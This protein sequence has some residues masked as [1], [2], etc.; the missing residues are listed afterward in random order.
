M[1]TL[2]LMETKLM[3]KVSTLLQALYVAISIMIVDLST[4]QL[5]EVRGSKDF[6]SLVSNCPCFEIGGA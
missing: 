6:H 1:F 2:M 3:V 4:I 5:L